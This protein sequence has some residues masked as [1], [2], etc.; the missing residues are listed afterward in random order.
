MK[1]IISISMLLLCLLS[2]PQVALA[3]EYNVN[4]QEKSMQVILVIPAK[5]LFQ[6]E[7]I[8]IKEEIEI[9]N[10]LIEPSHTEIDGY[11]FRGWYNGEYK[12]NFDEDIVTEH[13]TLIAKYTPVEKFNINI[14][15]DENSILQPA[16][17][18]K[19][20]LSTEFDGLVETDEID[21]ILE[22]KDAT[23][24]VTENERQ[25]IENVLEDNNLILG[26]YIDISM[27]MEI[28]KDPLTKK[29]IHKTK[30][31]ARIELTI[32]ENIRFNNKKYYLLRLHDG[33]VDTV[34]EGF[35]SGDWKISFETDKFSIYAIAYT[36]EE[37]ANIDVNIPKTG[38]NIATS[39]V[40]L[41]ISCLGLISILCY[42]VISSK[43]TLVK[44]NN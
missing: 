3:Q 30:N 36:E 16:I 41:I 33:V 23:K 38:D 21:I 29:A 35:P 37:F 34:F 40:M 22:V 32:P 2:I 15:V 19:V 18:N 17:L 42:K 10:K 8:I 11:V 12:W 28:N 5:V 20:D 7:D 6:N 43:R 4:E 14:K 27:F 26:K 13:L 24:L 39:F 9:G 1:K 25:I 31:M 44:T